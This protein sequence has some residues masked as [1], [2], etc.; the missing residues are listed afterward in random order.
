VPV[1]IN[2]RFFA[3]MTISVTGWDEHMVERR[4][5][6]GPDAR[7]R[8]PFTVVSSGWGDPGHGLKRK[9]VHATVTYQRV[10]DPDAHDPPSRNE[11]K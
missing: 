5:L 11:V 3:G 7:R 6:P 2:S 9:P 10:S 4:P 1:S 8:R